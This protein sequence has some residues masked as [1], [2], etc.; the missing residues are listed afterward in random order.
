MDYS[1][2]SMIYLGR[3]SNM[4]VVFEDKEPVIKTYIWTRSAQLEE[5][6]QVDFS[7]DL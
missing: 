4:D 5:D 2:P 6:Y 7:R 1:G 3:Q